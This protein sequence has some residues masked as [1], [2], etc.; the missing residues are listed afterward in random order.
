MP[1]F[2]CWASML[3]YPFHEN[4]SVST[5][6]I[7]PPPY[8]NMLTRVVHSYEIDLSYATMQASVVY[9]A[10]NPNT[11]Q[12]ISPATTLS[13][14]LRIESKSQANGPYQACQ[15]TSWGWRRSKKLTPLS[16]MPTLPAQC[17]KHFRSRSETMARHR[18]RKLSARVTFRNHVVMG[19]CWNSIITSL[20]HGTHHR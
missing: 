9:T 15:S 18:R 13:N 19:T 10:R 4:R 16:I 7:A 14:F 6:L 8:R 1:L 11:V 3:A 2:R 20:D 17:R 12:W 5:K